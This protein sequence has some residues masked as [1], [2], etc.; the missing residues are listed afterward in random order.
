LPDRDSEGLHLRCP[1]EGPNA[2]C[3]QRSPG[4]RAGLRP[5]RAVARAATAHPVITIRVKPKSPT[6]VTRGSRGSAR[7]GP[8]RGRKVQGQE[9]PTP[10]TTT[11]RTTASA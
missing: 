11:R 4:G 10:M 5:R 8:H 9:E 2:A 3:G 6:V 7:R 1:G